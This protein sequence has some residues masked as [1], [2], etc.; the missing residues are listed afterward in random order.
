[1]AY[2]ENAVEILKENKFKI[3]KARMAV[4]EI[5]SN[6]DKVLSFNNI[7]QQN[8]EKKLDNITVYRFLQILEK[9]HLSKKIHALNGYVS[10]EWE[11][12]IHNH[13]FLVC[14]K[15]GFFQEKIFE[16][17]EDFVCNLGIY[18]DQHSIEIVWLC[19]DCK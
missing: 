8:L 11:C 13:Y 9:L 16:G 18:P 10:C 19:K 17:E 2:K 4:L 12:H 15:C 1:M 14:S 3:T 6:S 5:L 7:V